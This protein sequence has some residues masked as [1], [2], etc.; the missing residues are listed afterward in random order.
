[1]IG[2]QPPLTAA[3]FIVKCPPYEV[4]DPSLPGWFCNPLADL[5]RSNPRLQALVRRMNLPF[6]VTK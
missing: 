3:R 2:I 5:L 4:H 1:M 6:A